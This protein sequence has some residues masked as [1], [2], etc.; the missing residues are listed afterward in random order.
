MS[1]VPGVD[2]PVEQTEVD[3]RLASADISVTVVVEVVQDGVISL[4][5]STSDFVGQSVVRPGD[6][7]EVY[8]KTGD[9]HRAV[10]TE[11]LDAQVGAVVR[12]RLAITGP[13]E[14][15]QR[16]MAVRG[17][18]AVPVELTASG[19]QVT[20]QTV[21]LSE[22]GLRAQFD[23][24]GLPPEGGTAVSLVLTL[25]DGPLRAAG[26]VIRLHI[27][28]AVWTVSATFRGIEEK[29]EDRIRRRVFQALREERARLAE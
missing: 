24:F 1:S 5:P 11:V 17:R 6:V 8:W 3:V 4:R 29:D 26:E 27:H 16:R 13:A 20:G 2:H 9:G 15:S 21:D 23:G 12:W 19:T 28:G 25:E 7:V 14:L 18:V 22:G 10:P